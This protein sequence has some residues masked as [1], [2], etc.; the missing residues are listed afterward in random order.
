[1]EDLRMKICDIQM[2]IDVICENLLSFYD[3]SL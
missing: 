2:M 3:I 1:M